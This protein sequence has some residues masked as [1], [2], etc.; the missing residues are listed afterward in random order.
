MKEL[1]TSLSETAR[2]G[3]MHDRYIL[4][5]RLRDLDERQCLIFAAWTENFPILKTAH[6]CKETFFEI[7]SATTRDQAQV[8][9]QIW[10]HDLPD[11]LIPAFQP[12]LTALE[13]W[14]TEIIAYFDHRI[15]NG[16]TEALN[17]LIKLA[18]RMGRG[19]SFETIR[20]KI[21]LTYGLR[22]KNYHDATS[23]ITFGSK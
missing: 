13:N 11:E 15:S 17:G 18:Q 14:Y 9:Y 23:T 2:R 3:L 12:L 5:R 10:Q 20:A 22:E 7:W 8:L 1:R 6:T 19:Y 16:P 21:L 4:L